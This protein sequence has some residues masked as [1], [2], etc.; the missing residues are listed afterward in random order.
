MFSAFIILSTR[1]RMLFVITL[2]VGLSALL[3]DSPS[4]PR[5]LIKSPSRKTSGDTR[6]H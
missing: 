3:W 6:R 5:I 4:R 2:V 1:T